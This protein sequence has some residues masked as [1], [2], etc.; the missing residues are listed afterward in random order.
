MPIEINYG[1]PTLFYAVTKH[2][3]NLMPLPSCP[4]LTGP[5]STI[6]KVSP[7]QC[8]GQSWQGMGR[9]GL[10]HD[11]MPIKV[12]YGKPSLFYAVTKNCLN[13]SVAA[14]LLSHITDLS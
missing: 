9:I 11:G 14:A 13:S 8:S 12:N 3:L 1:E 2:H 10:C 7:D 5:A 4:H 6:S